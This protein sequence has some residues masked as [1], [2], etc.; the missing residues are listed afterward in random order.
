M[1]PKKSHKQWLIEVNLKHNNFYSY[2]EEYVYST[3]NIKIICPIHGEFI[4]KANVHLNGSSCPKCSKLNAI[5]KRTK[6]HE[7]WLV[8]VN[9]KHNNFYS[10][11]E[12]YKHSEEKINIICPEHGLFKLIAINH[13]NGANC[14]KC[15]NK[16]ISK[17]K[18]K[19]HE[20]WLF[21]AN[22][23]HNNFYSYPEEYKHS[24]EK[25]NI[26]CPKHGIFLQT[27]NSHLNGSGCPKCSL[28]KI[29]KISF[30]ELEL[31]DFVKSLNINN[32][33]TSNRNIL[34]NK[35]LDLYF[36]DYNIAI[37][38]NGIYWHSDKYKDKYYHINKTNECLSKNIKLIHIFEDEWI[39]KKEIVKSMIK[40]NFNIFDN[41]ININQC[42]IKE[43]TEDLS[44]QFFIKNNIYDFIKSDK[45]IGLYFENKL[46]S[47][48]SFIKNKIIQFSDIL[49]TEINKSQEILI[50]YYLNKYKSKNLIIELDKNWFNENNIYSKLGFKL[51]QNK[52]PDYKFVDKLK[53]I[54][55]QSN[56]GCEF[57]KIYDCGYL[58]Y[59]YA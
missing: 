5:K 47:L 59:N 7:Q 41:K 38:F 49:N 42:E 10:Y 43:I 31:F 57:P 30:L 36:P 52:N 3:D 37:E 33:Q 14:P 20:Q 39:N 34:H 51:I 13:L 1:K 56:N 15:I 54:D 24:Q 21:E 50:N 26:I 23:K 16:N 58:I 17:L 35:E 9:L 40:N 29:N 25:I 53:R 44:F 2:P 18:T 48:I 28:E 8:E 11:P 6:S 22:L 32:I 4:Q 55:K 27:P 19:S 45:Y 46:V 12:E